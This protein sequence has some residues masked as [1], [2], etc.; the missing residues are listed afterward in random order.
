MTLNV[1][2]QVF[3]ITIFGVSGIGKLLHRSNFVHTLNQLPLSRWM[4][5]VLSVLVPLGELLVC[6][7]LIIPTVQAFGYGITLLLSMS[8]IWAGIQGM[9][10]K[11]QVDCHCFGQF[12][13]EKLGW[14]TLVKAMLLIVVSAYSLWRNAAANLFL[15]DWLEVTCAIFV[16]IA[17]ILLYTFLGQLKLN[18]Q[19][20]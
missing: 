11:K 1:F 9:S 16:S 13:E 5:P 3:L 4:P 20:G 17:V 2:I 6:I 19:G 12:L 18:R 8:F 7:C 10:T 15:I 14:N